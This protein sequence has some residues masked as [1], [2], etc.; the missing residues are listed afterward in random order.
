MSDCESHFV[1]YEVLKQFVSPTEN[2]GLTV[3]VSQLWAKCELSG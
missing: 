3:K 1:S 2:M